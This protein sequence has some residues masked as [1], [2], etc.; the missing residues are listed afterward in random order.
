V[1]RLLYT[2]RGTKN[3]FFD[4]Q[5][6]RSLVKIK[7]KKGF[8]HL[9]QQLALI[10]ELEKSQWNLKVR[11][12]VAVLKELEKQKVIQISVQKNHYKRLNRPTGV[13]K[14][15]LF[16]IE[17]LE[18]ELKNFLPVK[19]QEVIQDQENCYGTCWC[20]DTLF[21]MPVLVG[22]TIKYLFIF[23]INWWVWLDGNPW[24]R[25][26]VLLSHPEKV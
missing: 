26:W 15:F 22:E 1:W 4:I 17:P 7:R 16:H 13:L 21:R 2:I 19:F 6:I 20:N 5:L 3:K 11:A 9:F 25:S 23:V 14:K 8:T 24:K 18:G 12:C 10:W